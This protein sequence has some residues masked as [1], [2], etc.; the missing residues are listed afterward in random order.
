[1][2]CPKGKDCHT[3]EKFSTVGWLGNNCG[4]DWKILSVG[5]FKAVLISHSN[6]KS[7]IRAIAPKTT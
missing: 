7:I 3:L 5:D 1:M 2:Y 6:G 4:G